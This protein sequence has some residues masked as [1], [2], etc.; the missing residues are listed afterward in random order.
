MLWLRLFLS[1]GRSEQ[2]L[3]S[4]VADALTNCFLLGLFSMLLEADLS[5]HLVFAHVLASIELVGRCV[6]TGE[7]RVIGRG[8]IQVAIILL[9][10]K[11]WSGV[12]GRQTFDWKALPLWHEVVTGCSAILGYS[13]VKVEV[14]VI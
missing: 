14:D 4:K 12:G 3:I 1:G 11:E 6:A 13:C 7:S 10:L 9:G 8:D 2:N 5:H